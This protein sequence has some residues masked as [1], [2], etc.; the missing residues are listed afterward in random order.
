[1]IDKPAQVPR[2]A[3]CDVLG[4]APTPMQSCGETG[5]ER[6]TRGLAHTTQTQVPLSQ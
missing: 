2:L 3:L 5:E 4:A 1:M 6:T